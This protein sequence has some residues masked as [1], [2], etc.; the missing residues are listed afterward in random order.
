MGGVAC[1]ILLRDLAIHERYGVLGKRF[2]IVV[3]LLFSIV[4]HT[5]CS[6][7]IAIMLPLDTLVLCD[8][9]T[10]YRRNGQSWDEKCELVDRWSSMLTVMTNHML[11]T[12]NPIN[13]NLLINAVVK[14]R[15]IFVKKFMR[16]H[17]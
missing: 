5:D 4:G 7:S 13:P 17:G 1:C 11:P 2:E 12:S 10:E 8:Y 15:V 3:E 6:L 9:G 16:N 14:I